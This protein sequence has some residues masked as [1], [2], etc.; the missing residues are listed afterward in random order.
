MTTQDVRYPI[1]RFSREAPLTSE[2]RRECIDQIAALPSR[3]T[4]VLRDLSEVELGARYR[5]GG[6]TVRQVVHHIADSHINAYV[7]FRLALTE[8]TPTIKPYDK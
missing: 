1:G 7:R 5:A 2:R 6:W 4:E 3:L 8:D